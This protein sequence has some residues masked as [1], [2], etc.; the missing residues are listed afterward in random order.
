[1]APYSS[2]ANDCSSHP[3]MPKPTECRRPRFA[4]LDGASLRN[5]GLGFALLVTGVL[6]ASI[7]L[8]PPSS[9]RSETSQ[10]SNAQTAQLV[11][12]NKN[13]PVSF[14][15]PTQPQTPQEEP[16]KELPSPNRAKLFVS[17]WSGSPYGVAALDLVCPADR[18][19]RVRPDE[20]LSLTES[21]QRILAVCFARPELKT[22]V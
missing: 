17:A 4:K 11:Q 15:L 3:S 21:K 22:S 14:I 13:F 1:M 7:A 18:K 10:L 16:P 6:A 9:T 20:M 12:N 8:R 5:L 2:S 19:L